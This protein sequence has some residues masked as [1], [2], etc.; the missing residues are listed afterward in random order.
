MK[1]VYDEKIKKNISRV[2]LGTAKF[3]ARLSENDAEN[4]LDVFTQAG[5]TLLDTARNYDE[6]DING[7]GASEKCIGKW[8]QKAN[9]R[10]KMVICT[11]G[12]VLRG[13]Q[14]K[15]IYNLSKESLLTELQESL[16]VLQTE[17]IDIYLLHKDNE[18][19]PVEEVVDACQ[20]LMEV[21][22]IRKIGV[23]N[24]SLHRLKQANEYAYR[25]G[26]EP[27]TVGEYWWSLCEY[28]DAF[29]NDPKT[30]FLTSDLY[31]YLKEQNMLCLG[32]S[33]QCKGF[34]QKIVNTGYSSVP[35]FLVQRISTPRNL[36]KAGYIQRLCEE[37]HVSPT[38]IIQ[39]YITNNELNGVALISCSNTDQLSECMKWSDYQLSQNL[40]QAIDHI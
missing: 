35:S 26:L 23:S 16:N 12:G 2:G 14:E 32:Y 20:E 5:G 21:G 17:Y 22:N 33:S 19:F 38:A 25:H 11:K 18:D 31:C 1:Y 27:F 30:Y 3:G 29:W 36:I 39:S 8:L 15:R 37:K 9:R 4:Q 40:I 10:D 28:T 34:F 13:N 6:W 7:R 24:W